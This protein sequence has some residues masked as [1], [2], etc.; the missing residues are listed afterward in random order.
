MTNTTLYK[1]HLFVC[2]N[3]RDPKNDTLGCCGLKDRAELATKLKKMVADAGLKKTV[4]VNRA[5]CLGDCANGVVIV[6]YPEGIWLKNVGLKD[7]EQIF[8][9]YLSE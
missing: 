7:A 9:D 4:R 8:K 6:I 1:K 5:G 2:E 3:I